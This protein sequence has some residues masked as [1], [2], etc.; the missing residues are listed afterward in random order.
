MSNR[1]EMLVDGRR[2]PVIG[3]VCMDQCMLDVTDTP[4][5]TEGSVVTVFG[6]DGD[7]TLPVDELAAWMNSIHYEVVCLVSK[8]VSRLYMD[9]DGTVDQL[10]YLITE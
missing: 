9:A 10:N 2:A 1:A 7:G 5:V 6:R 8:R 4:S 3:R